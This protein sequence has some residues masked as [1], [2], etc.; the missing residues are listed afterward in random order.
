MDSL[1]SSSSRKTA[2]AQ[3]MRNLEKAILQADQRIR[4]RRVAS[5]NAQL[6]WVGM[7]SVPFCSY[8]IYNF[9]AAGGV[10]QNWKSSSGAYMYYAQNWMLKPRSATAVYRPEIEMAQ[11]SAPLV[12][13]TRKIEAQR[14]AGEL[15]EGADAVHHPTSWH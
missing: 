11:Q 4:M 2:P 15:P 8:L 9:F 1:N 14:A 13:Y 5:T 7:F 6:I 12:A 10:M 3:H